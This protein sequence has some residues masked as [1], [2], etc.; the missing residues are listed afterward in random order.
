MGNRTAKQTHGH[1]ISREGWEEKCLGR[2]KEGGEGQPRRPGML[3]V[4]CP[5][6]LPA[7]H[8]VLYGISGILSTRHAHAC[9]KKSAHTVLE[10]IGPIL[11]QLVLS[12]LSQNVPHMQKHM[13]GWDVACLSQQPH[14]Y[15]ERRCRLPAHT[16]ERNAIKA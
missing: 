10:G 12:C 2:E 8:P 6:Q 15:T 1:T 7:C 13:K 9:Y 14:A 4:Q 3:P 16:G 11:A 5:S